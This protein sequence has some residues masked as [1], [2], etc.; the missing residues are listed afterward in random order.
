MKKL[1]QT[2]ILFLFL[3]ILIFSVFA[4]PAVPPNLT[5][6][7]QDLLVGI[8]KE[9]C[10]Y[11]V[12]NQIRYAFP[13]ASFDEKVADDYIYTLSDVISYS[14]DF[15]PSVEK[16]FTIYLGF[17]PDQNQSLYE[18][19]KI[20]TNRPLSYDDVWNILQKLHASSI[21]SAEQYGLFAEY[22]LTHH[23]LSA[24]ALQ[25][26]DSST[27]N[28]ATF[29]DDTDHLYYLDF[30]LPMLDSVY[31]SKTENNTVK[32]AVLDFSNWYVANHSFKEYEKLCSSLEEQSSALVDAKNAWLKEI[33]CSSTYSE[34]DKLFFH[35]NA[36]RST[37]YQFETSD[38]IWLWDDADVQ[39]LG[40]V[41]MVSNFQVLLPLS[42]LDFADAREYYKEYLPSDLGKVT[43]LTQFTNTACPYSFFDSSNTQISIPFGWW[44]AGRSLL[45]EY[46]HFLTCGDE[47]ILSSGDTLFAE[48]F[49]VAPSSIT[50]ENRMK[51]TFL[52][53]YLGKEYLQSEGYWDE[54][55]DSFSS[56]LGTC[57]DALESFSSR[58]LSEASGEV[59]Q[60]TLSDLDYAEQGVLA[61]YLIET[62]GMDF[63]VELA[64]AQCN[65]EDVLGE[66]LTDL[67]VEAMNWVDQ[68]LDN[69]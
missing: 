55:T 14:N 41:D 26:D 42:E 5:W 27:M 32:K 68:S 62:R 58:S 60:I 51:E 49:S 65:Y 45:H 46:C 9:P 53:E 11:T 2:C 15:F 63:L 38:A 50:L 29:F 37:T 35:Y 52:T 69:R 44:E 47:K 25:A 66:S 1:Q 64:K 16:D 24:D 28:L 18:K 22:C 43:I 17:E 13:A 3:L 36:T 61:E 10:V 67:Y 57:K 12:Y 39:S 7:N 59:E 33:G 48:W 34:F 56:S 6:E 21:D 31:F 40:Y 54:T 19:A 30:T 8:A 4:K 23:L 20:P